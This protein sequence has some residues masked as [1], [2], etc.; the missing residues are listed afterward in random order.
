MQSNF[1]V[2][3]VSSAGRSPQTVFITF[4]EEIRKH[5]D[6]AYC[7]VEGYDEPYY[8]PRVTSQSN[9][10]TVHFVKSYGKKIVIEFYEL[11]Q[12]KPEYDKYTKM[13]FVDSDYDDNSSLN[14]NIY[15][16][17]C[18]SVENFYINKSVIE[19]FTDNIIQLNEQDL[20]MVKAANDAAIK[21][22]MLDFFSEKKDE[23]LEAICPFCA[24][25]KCVK[26]ASNTYNVKLDETFPSSYVEIQVENRSFVIEN[27][28]YDLAKLNAD[29]NTSVSQSD[30]DNA[31]EY[32][33]TNKDYYIRGKYILQFIERLLSFWVANSK[34]PKAQRDFSIKEINFNI[35]KKRLMSDL[36]AYAQSP[37]CL[38]MYVQNQM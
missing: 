3:A 21:K 9:D 10:K 19:G 38:A 25:Y 18:Y 29:F 12:K 30:Y 7:F 8:R 2:A 11:I 36:S 32:I 4:C 28:G 16:T 14:S 17:P 35:N 6:G 5:G 26:N 27:K 37:S 31:L 13:F 20:D 1:S 33:R 34:L 23:W 22:K 24:W 15:R